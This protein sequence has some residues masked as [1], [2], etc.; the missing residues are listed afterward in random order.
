MDRLSSVGCRDFLST[1]TLESPSLHRFCVIATRTSGYDALLFTM[2]C[3]SYVLLNRLVLGPFLLDLIYGEK[4]SSMKEADKRAFRL[5]HIGI[6]A[7]TTSLLLVSKPAFMVALKSKEWSDPY[8]QGSNITLGEVA[9]FSIMITAGFHL[10][11]LIF[12]QSLKPLL[13]IHH[14]GSIM[15]I[16]GFLP[17]LMSLPKAQNMELN[18]AISMA[19]VTLYWGMSAIS[20]IYWL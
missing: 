15:V 8:S 13:I 3:V 16:H 14:L 4:Y 17:A 6:F 18:R 2:L 20:C 5:R 11:E 12:D 9:F 10:F 19:N 7:R 1:K